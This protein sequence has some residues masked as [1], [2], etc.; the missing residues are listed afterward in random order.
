[1]VVGVVG[2]RLLL[3]LRLLLQHVGRS[4]RLLIKHR[5]RIRPAQI[6]P[7]S[8]LVRCRAGP[9]HAPDTTRPEHTAPLAKE[10]L[11]VTGAGVLRTRREGSVRQHLRARQRAAPGRLH[12]RGPP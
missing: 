4:R 5:R 9:Q 10:T 3:L 7:A 8:R 11:H 2:L 12:W 6:L 1:M